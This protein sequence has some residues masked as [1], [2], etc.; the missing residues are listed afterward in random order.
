MLVFVAIYL[1]KMIGG[2]PDP[3]CRKFGQFIFMLNRQQSVANLSA[4][5][6]FLLQLYKSGH[7]RGMTVILVKE[8]S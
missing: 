8:N 6:L 1:A 3:L 4:E 5:R 2:P 7:E